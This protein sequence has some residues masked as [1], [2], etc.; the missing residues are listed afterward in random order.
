[1]VYAPMAGPRPSALRRTVPPPAPALPAGPAS[2]AAPALP[3]GPAARTTRG[4]VYRRMGEAFF[5]PDGDRFVATE[6]TRG[7]WDPGAQ[8]AGPP[9]ALLGRAVERF[10]TREDVQVVRV[11]FEILLQVPIA[12]LEIA[13]T[14]LRGADNG[15]WAGAPPSTD[16]PEVSRARGFRTRTPAPPLDGGVAGRRPGPG[17]GDPEPAAPPG[18]E[19]GEP[20]RFFPTRHKIG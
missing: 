17:Q 13:T 3:T 1:M 15:E 14:L 11:T 18:P 6:L 5:L 4:V 19:H 12:P 7:P 16:G 9:A 2:P 10:G 20:L 8:H